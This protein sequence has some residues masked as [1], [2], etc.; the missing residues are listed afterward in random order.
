MIFQSLAWLFDDT[1]TL[2]VWQKLR[3]KFQ[4]D[5]IFAYL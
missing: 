2:N 4:N 5:V 3:L 1:L